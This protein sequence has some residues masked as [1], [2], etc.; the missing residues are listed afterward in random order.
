MALHGPRRPRSM[1][2]EDRLIHHPTDNQRRNTS[3]PSVDFQRGYIFINWALPLSVTLLPLK[4]SAVNSQAFQLDDAVVRD[5]RV[6][7]SNHSKFC[8]LDSAGSP[9]SVT[10]V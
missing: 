7:R 2:F 4:V 9:A 1:N 6:H 3:A 5:R 8:R 10:R